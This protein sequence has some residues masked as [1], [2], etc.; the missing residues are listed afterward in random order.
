MSSDQV[1]NSEI[2]LPTFNISSILSQFVDI[3]KFLIFKYVNLGDPALNNMVS[4]ILMVFVTYIIDCIKALGFKG[5]WGIIKGIKDTGDIKSVDITTTG[6]IKNMPEFKKTHKCSDYNLHA[7]KPADIHMKED[8]RLWVQKTYPNEVYSQRVNTNLLESYDNF[9]TSNGNYFE[10]FPIYQFPNNDVIYYHCVNNDANDF[11]LYCRDHNNLTSFITEV[12]YPFAK[13]RRDINQVVVLNDNTSNKR[14]RKCN[15]YDAMDT[16][17]VISKVNQKRT[18]DVLVF[19]DKS[20]I[21]NMI[22]QFQANVKSDSVYVS[23]NLG[24]LLYGEPGTGKTS[25]IKAMCNYFQRD[26]VVIDFTRVTSKSKFTSIINN[27][28]G[29]V[30][31]F[32]E[33]DHL[34]ESLHEMQQEPSTMFDSSMFHNKGKIKTQKDSKSQKETKDKDKDDNDDRYD[35]FYPPPNTDKL[36]MYTILT[37]LDGICEHEDRI[38][39][40]TTNNIQAIDKKL[41]RPGRFDYILQLGR[42]IHSEIV[43]LLGKIYNLD[44]QK[45]EDINKMYKFPDNV[46]EPVRIITMTRIFPTLEDLCNELADASNRPRY[47]IC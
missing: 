34:I 20:K 10:E 43:E 8:I 24:I 22:K 5:I 11:T 25:I 29:K 12:I 15:I 18:F 38:I 16:N 2:K 9:K 28:L 39:I 27:E 46:W 4:L 6:I 36:D 1:N 44:P 45:M 23:K 37:T 32:E 19:K 13:S 7:I 41:I 40:A 33:F 35:A 14:L 21:I 26:A 47:E 3:S 30:I 31:I 42:F 17:T